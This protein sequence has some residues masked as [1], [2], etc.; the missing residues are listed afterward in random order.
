M[1]KEERFDRINSELA[2]RGNVD[3]DEL[4]ELLGVSRTTI[5]RDLDSMES[6]GLLERTHGGAT[7]VRA[8]DELP[9]FSKMAAYLPEKRAIGVKT[10]SLIPE[11]AVI[12]CS[13]GTTVMQTIKALRGKRLMVVTNAVNV[14]MELASS[15]SVQVIV[16]GG[17]LSARTF[18]LVGHIADKTLESFHFDIVLLG[19]D[20]ISVDRGLS[21]YT[22]AD[23]HTDSLYM[24]NAE[25]TWVVSD[26]SKIGKIAPVLI[27]P[28]SKV[29]RLITDPGL[30]AADRRALESA[31]VEVLIAEP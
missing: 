16:T 18:E 2:K 20:G 14:A 26:H 9:F 23:A 5:R 12:G 1:L 13:G 24:E 15:E 22:V 21:T 8:D 30:E 10:A 7:A 27:S 4:A 25:A 19:V 3:G 6:L 28:L 17:S 31:G 11:N 29:K